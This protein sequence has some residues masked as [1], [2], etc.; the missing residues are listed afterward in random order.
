ATHRGAAATRVWRLLRPQSCRSASQG[1]RLEPAEASAARSAAR[2][3]EAY[4]R[5]ERA[6]VARAQKKAK[7]EGQSIL[8]ADE[9]GFYPLPAVV[10]TW[11]PCGQTPILRELC[12]RD[13]LSAIGAV[14]PQGALYLRFQDH[15]L[16]SHDVVGFLRYVLR[17]IRGKIL[18]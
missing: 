15:S 14:S 7:E 4:L 10:R 18:L 17:Q 3:R 2:R 13:H 11:A 12:T 5:V 6:K 9:S 16:N 1:D 8:F